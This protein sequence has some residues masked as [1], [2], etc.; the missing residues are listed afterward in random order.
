MNPSIPKLTRFPFISL[1]KIKAF[2][3]LSNQ[4]KHLRWKLAILAGL[5]RTMPKAVKIMHPSLH[6][7]PILPPKI[8][9]FTKIHHLELGLLRIFLRSKRP[10]MRPKNAQWVVHQSRPFRLV[11]SRNDPKTA[12]ESSGQPLAAPPNCLEVNHLSCRTAETQVSSCFCCSKTD[13]SRQVT[14]RTLRQKVLYC[15][16]VTTCGNR[17]GI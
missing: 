3:T 14:G 2:L 1:H 5:R 7:S 6:P 9:D 4:A 8:R 11:T 10:N 17:V 16:Q 13:H 15:L 12:S